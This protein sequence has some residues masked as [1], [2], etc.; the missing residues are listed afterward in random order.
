MST[1]PQAV[2]HTSSH[3]QYTTPE[4]LYPSDGSGPGSSTTSIESPK[5]ARSSST[6]SSL[7]SSSKHSNHTG[8]IVGGV[9]GGLAVL[10]L[11]TVATILLRRRM[12]ARHTA[13]SAEFMGLARGTLTPGP[14]S[15]L[16]R[17]AG[18]M[19]P[20]GDRLLSLA[21]QRSLDDDDDDRPPAF[22]PGAYADPV[23]EKVQ[24]AAAMREQ[25]KPHDSYYGGAQVHYKEETSEMGHEGESAQVG[26]EEGGYELSGDEKAG[27]YTWAM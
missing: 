11:A 17:T 5:G 22:T 6:S 19:T 18:T 1:S 12:R 25:Y 23:L 20:S 3:S 2:V 15:G 10:L 8:T 27:Y 24:V 13:P 14:G 7:A 4:P 9:I 21:P 16:V 26:T